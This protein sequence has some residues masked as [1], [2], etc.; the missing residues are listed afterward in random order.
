MRLRV[1]GGI[2]IHPQ[3]V[4]RLN[5]KK[6]VAS[7]LCPCSCVPAGLN[8]NL[9]VSLDMSSG[10]G[11]MGYKEPPHSKLKKLWATTD[12][13]EQNSKSGKMAKNY[14]YCV[15]VYIYILA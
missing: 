12:P 15:C 9:N 8:S 14:I 6:E 10:G 11:A 7:F 2:R 3:F 13:L 4:P 1:Q 5:T